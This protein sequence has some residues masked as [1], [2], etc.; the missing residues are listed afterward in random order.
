MHDAIFDFTQNSLHEDGDDNDDDDEEDE[1]ED[2][3]DNGDEYLPTKTYNKSNW[4]HQPKRKRGR[5]KKIR[6]PDEI[7]LDKS[8]QRNWREGKIFKC[9]HCVKKFTRR[10]R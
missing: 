3:D 10:T 5:P 8:K 9:P 6:P 4:I 7:N 2:E 1:D